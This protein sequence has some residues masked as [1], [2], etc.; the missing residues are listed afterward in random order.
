MD[1]L[2]AEVMLSVLG[3]V[4]TSISLFSTWLTISWIAFAGLDTTATELSVIE[5]IFKLQDAQPSAIVGSLRDT[6][7]ETYS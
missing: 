3:F 7:V 5:S 6:L 2:I 1:R 4:S